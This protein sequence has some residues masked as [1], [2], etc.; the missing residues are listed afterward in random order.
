MLAQTFPEIRSA[1]P[2]E[3]QVEA[4]PELRNLVL[5]DNEES[6]HDDLAQLRI[7]SM[8]DWRELLMWREGHGV[9]QARRDISARL[10][11]DDVINL[12]FTRYIPDILH[13]FALLIENS[14]TTGC[15]KAVSVMFRQGYRY[16]VLICQSSLHTRIYSTMLSPS[17]DVCISPRK[18]F[19]VRHLF[20]PQHLRYLNLMKAMYPH[21]S[22]VLIS[23]LLPCKIPNSSDLSFHKHVLS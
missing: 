22:T 23:S 15:P 6:A 20:L 19:S 18:M 1:K 5:V 13:K 3:I 8:I 9:A 4:L 2:G 12:Q 16:R 10:E 11:I 17:L 14:G 21:Y 7:K